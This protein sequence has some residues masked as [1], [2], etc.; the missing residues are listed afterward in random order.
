[1]GGVIAET[2]GTGTVNTQV[3]GWITI[4]DGGSWL[5][6]EK[7]APDVKPRAPDD[8]PPMAPPKPL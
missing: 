2:T 4:S 6:L 7:L 3:G 5:V 1:M 8:P